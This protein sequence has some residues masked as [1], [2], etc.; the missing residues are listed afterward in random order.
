MASRTATPMMAAPAS[1]VS[2]H[3]AHR[4]FRPDLRSPGTPAEG[5]DVRRRSAPLVGRHRVVHG[6]VD[7]RGPSEA[8]DRG[9]VGHN[10]LIGSGSS[11]PDIAGRSM[12]CVIS[13]LLRQLGEQLALLR[14]QRRRDLRVHV[15]EQLPGSGS[16]PSITAARASARNRAER[17]RGALFDA[18]GHTPRVPGRSGSG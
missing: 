6:P 18:F 11:P 5:G 9:Q 13:G 17:A 8:G 14:R 2:K 1:G 15:V 7:G 12:I 10:G 4:R 16:G 3:L